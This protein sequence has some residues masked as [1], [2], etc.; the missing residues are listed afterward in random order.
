MLFFLNKTKVLSSVIIKWFL[1]EK[2]SGRFFFSFH[3]VIILKCVKCLSYSI[4][5][6]R[7]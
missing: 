1:L 4:A 7:Q 5:A 6:K 3:V 2:S